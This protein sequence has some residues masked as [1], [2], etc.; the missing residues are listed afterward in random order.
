MSLSPSLSCSLEQR[1]ETP[2]QTALQLYSENKNI[3]VF[4]IYGNQ[5]IAVPMA[6]ISKKNIKA[7]LGGGEK[8]S[9]TIGGMFFITRGM[10]EQYRHFAAIHELAEHSAPRGFDVTGLAKHFQAIAVEMGYA[11]KI[12]SSEEYKKYFEWRKSVE[13]TD[14][15]NLNDNGIIDGIRDKFGEI[16]ESLSSYLTYRKKKLVKLI[17]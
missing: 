16:F 6:L 10:P 7:V 9:G 4:V 14:F 1:L 17:R 12:L 15:F 5:K 8:Y 3:N 13:K 2:Y 11:K